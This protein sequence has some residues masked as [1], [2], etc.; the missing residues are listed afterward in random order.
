MNKENAMESTPQPVKEKKP[1]KPR[2]ASNYRVV[3]D[4]GKNADDLPTLIV[5]GSGAK[6][7]TAWQDAFQ[8]G[9][10]GNAML[11]CVR[12][13]PRMIGE[14]RTFGFLKEVK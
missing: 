13:R 6:P 10:P 1:R 9:K 4:G 2:S 8:R 11:I 5:V 12:G 7:R 14:Q 3:I